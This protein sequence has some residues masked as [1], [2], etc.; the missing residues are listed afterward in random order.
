MDPAAAARAD[1]A[2]TE[3]VRAAGILFLTP[4]GE[5]LLVR[6]TGAGDHAGEWSIPGGKIEGDETAEEAA[7]REAMEEVGWEAADATLTE[8]TRQR[9]DNV[10]FTTFLC[11]LDARFEAVVDGVENDE[12]MWAKRDELLPLVTAPKAEPAPAVVGDEKID[13]RLATLKARRTG[14]ED[15]ADAD[16]PRPVVTIAPDGTVSVYR[17][18]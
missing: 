13:R 9:R 5:V 8:W 11:K 16:D 18:A 1:D 15:S 6:R 2:E 12:Q 14:R 7:R 3:I 10:D 4:D 17:A